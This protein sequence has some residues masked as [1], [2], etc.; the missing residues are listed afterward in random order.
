MD[1][2]YTGETVEFTAIVRQRC[3]AHFKRP[4]WWIKS[5]TEYHRIDLSAAFSSSTLFYFLLLLIF[6]LCVWGEESLTTA[7]R[8]VDGLTVT[9]DRGPRGQ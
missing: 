2:V 5:A 7:E 9:D 1:L 6:I 3:L 4:D 8:S